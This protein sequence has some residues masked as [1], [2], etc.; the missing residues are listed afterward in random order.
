MHLLLSL[1]SSF[2]SYSTSLFPPHKFST[3]GPRMILRGI[4]GEIKIQI[5][6]DEFVNARLNCF[7][8]FGVR[9]M[10]WVV[11]G[12]DKTRL[13]MRMEDDMYV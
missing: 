1:F 13:R 7:C 6:F 10:F 2:A 9:M 5:G 3:R 4:L 11:D 8:W 12:L